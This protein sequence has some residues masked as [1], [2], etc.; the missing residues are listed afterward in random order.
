M[1]S[2]EQMFENEKVLG[3]ECNCEINS[4]CKSSPCDFISWQ[5][6]LKAD[7]PDSNNT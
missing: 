7:F 3:N 2:T 4:Q 1:S 6:F 5:V